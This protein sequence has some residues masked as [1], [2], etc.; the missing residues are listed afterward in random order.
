MLKLVGFAFFPLDL[1]G[2]PSRIQNKP[3]LSE[4]FSVVLYSSQI[5][6]FKHRATSSISDSPFTS[7][8]KLEV[9]VFM[10]HSYGKE[11]YSPFILN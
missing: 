9:K 5:A 6:S 2:S 4:G 8:C 1:L 3:C 11:S 7:Y 10:M